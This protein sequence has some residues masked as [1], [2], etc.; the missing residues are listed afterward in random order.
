MPDECAHIR[1]T[2]RCVLPVLVGPN[3][4][5]RVARV[6]GI[7]INNAIYISRHPREAKRRSNP[8]LRGIT[9]DCFATLAMTNDK[10]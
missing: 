10:D 7:F 5:V 1:S 3:M 4:A 2:A 8:G 6:G 9:L